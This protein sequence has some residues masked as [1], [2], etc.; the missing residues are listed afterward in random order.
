MEEMV[1]LLQDAIKIVQEKQSSFLSQ[2][3]A[4]LWIKTKRGDLQYL[5]SWKQLILIRMSKKMN[6]KIQ[7]LYW[8]SLK[9]RHAKKLEEMKKLIKIHEVTPKGVNAQLFKR[10]NFC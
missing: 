1:L 3:L 4:Q 8:N 5:S 9:I 10:F 6:Q 2:F 7:Q